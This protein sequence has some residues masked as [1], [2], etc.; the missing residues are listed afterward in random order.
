MTPFESY[1][2]SP[3]FVRRALVLI[4]MFLTAC[5]VSWSQR[6]PM[7][8]LSF[9]GSH[10][11]RVQTANS[12]VPGGLNIWANFFELGPK[13]EGQADRWVF[14]PADSVPKPDAHPLKSSANQALEFPGAV[15]AMAV[16]PEGQRVWVASQNQLYF[17][18]WP[19]LKVIQKAQLPIPQTT[20]LRCLANEPTTLWLGGG[21]PGRGGSFLEIDS[22][23]QEIRQRW[24]LRQDVLWDLA[25]EPDGQRLALASHDQGVT[26]FD[27]AT[28]K[29]T[30]LQGHTGPVVAIAWLAPNQIVSAA[31]DQ[32]VRVWQSSD[33]TLTRS[34][35]LHNDRITAG[36]GPDSSHDSAWNTALGRDWFLTMADDRTIRYWQPNKG[37]LVRFV[38]LDE[39]P[40]AFVG[41]PQPLQVVAG[42]EDGGV[43]W[44]DLQHARAATPLKLSQDSITVLAVAPDRESLLAGTSGGQLLQFRLE[45]LP[46]LPPSDL[47]QNPR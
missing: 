1:W 22:N 27:R 13:L 16:H 25:I 19:G 34:M 2:N 9:S 24:D 15:T 17:L 11:I 39:R 21:H 7:E 29:A 38:R 4:V 18:E 10:P 32:T 3:Q 43:Q 35:E 47:L 42:T 14:P 36:I 8:R 44:V 5:E 40:T 30:H 20:C 6:L 41:L 45:S 28:G 26:L 31:A 23:R 37:R 12:A 33:G 46:L